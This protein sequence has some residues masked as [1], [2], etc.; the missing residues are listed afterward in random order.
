[1]LSSSTLQKLHSALNRTVKRAMARD[2]VKGNVVELCAVP[3]GP[4]AE[5][6]AGRHVGSGSSLPR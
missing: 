4:A 6:L 3:P 1:V 5:I 2:K